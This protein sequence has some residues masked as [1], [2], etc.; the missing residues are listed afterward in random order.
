MSKAR[1]ETVISSYSNAK[2]ESLYIAGEYKKT[3]FRTFFFEPKI[4][5]ELLEEY[6][7]PLPFAAIPSPKRVTPIMPKVREK[8]PIGISLAGI[9]VKKEEIIIDPEELK[10]NVFYLFSLRDEKY[11]VRKLEGDVIEIYEVIE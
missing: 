2:R 7:A 3:A 8:P 6:K 10:Q 1:R 5:K 4:Q 11:V 9:S